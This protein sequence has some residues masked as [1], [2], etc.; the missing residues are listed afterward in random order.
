M[1]F[2]DPQ[3]VDSVCYDLKIGDF[4]RAQKRALINN[5]FNGVPPHSEREVEEQNI[6]INFNDLTATLQG[7][8]ARSQLYSAFNKPGNYFTLTTDMGPGH[9]RAERGVT[10]TRE[11]NRIMKRSLEY[12][13]CYRSS[14][15]LDV[16]HGIG[17]ACWDGPERWCPDPLG[18]EDVLVPSGVNLPLRNM[19]RF[20][21]YRSYSWPEL[22]KLTSGPELDPG[23]NQE[24]L[25]AIKDWFKQHAQDLMGQNWP[26]VWSPDKVAENFKEDTGYYMGDRL[27]TIDVFDFYF[28]SDEKD[29]EGWYRRIILDSYSVPTMTA[30]TAYAMSRKSDAVFAK[31]QFL[32]TSGNRKIADSWKEIVSFQFADLSAV[33]PFRYHSIRSLGWLLYAPCMVQNLLRCKF[34]E[35][36]FENLMQYFRVRSFDDYQRALKVELINR[37]FIDETVQMIPQNERWQINQQLVD[38]AFL[39]W[40]QLIKRSGS[41]YKQ[42]TGEEADRTRKTAYQVQTEVT[43]TAG[44]VSAAFEQAYRYQTVQY[45]EIVRR[46]MRPHSTDP[47]VNTFRANCLRQGVPEKM[48]NNPEAWDCEPERVQGGGNKTIELAI[49]NWLMEHRNVY[50]PEPQRDILRQATLMVTD[51]PSFT[52]RL[53]PEK[54]GQITDSVHDAQLAAGVLM[55]GLPVSLKTG[56]N[57]IE[58]VET[59]LGDLAFLIKGVEGRGGMATAQEINGFQGIAQHIQQHIAI[60]GQDPNEKQRVK[61]YGDELGQLMNMVKAYAQRLQEAM[62][63][64]Q[65][66]QGGNG[67]IDPKDAA[68]IQA[69]ML[70]AQAKVQQ[71]K[72]SHAQRTAQRQI[73]FEQQQRQQSEKHAAEIQAIDL[74]TA[75][76]I[77]RER[78]KSLNEPKE[79]GG[80]KSD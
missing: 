63:K 1:L 69:T 24:M 48:L 68:K 79:K 59:L 73:Q 10:V 28:W 58:Y 74:Q 42:R 55:Q 45:H 15:A 72:Q 77:R 75:A 41:A 30:G 46:F 7:H 35:H 13:E 38:T 61:Q 80:E 2:D 32:Y 23:W 17:P 5:L 51:D 60:I 53:V 37:G 39:Q 56:L 9:K 8:D 6:K 16:L 19:D 14:L 4:P 50:D 71:G 62:Q 76:E 36:V 21:L 44:L 20:A 70:T 47:E 27:P 26:M 33:S 64:Q 54:A 66:A 57:H 3:S 67:Q 34:N 43:A 12:Y 78:L 29:R 40:D 49:A 52:Q 11:M 25:T 65:Q 18:I 22:V 31:H